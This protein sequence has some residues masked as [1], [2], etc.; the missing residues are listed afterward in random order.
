M[1]ISRENRSLVPKARGAGARAGAAAAV[2]IALSVACVVIPE[3]RA[4]TGDLLINKGQIVEA[5]ALMEAAER[6]L[7]PSAAIQVVLSNAY[8]RTAQQ[9]FDA[10]D[11]A[12]YVEHMEKAQRAALRALEINDR[13]ARAH[14]LLGIYSLYRGDLEGAIESFE[15]ARQIDP[16]VA[17]YTA[18][19]AELYVYLG[20][21]SKSR[22]RRDRARRLGAAPAALEL[23]DV[24]AAWQRGDYV[25]ARA[26]FDDTAM[27]NPQFVRTWNGASNIATFED[28]AAHCC[29]LPFCGPYMRNACSAI[30]AQVTERKLAEETALRE[31]QMKIE[32]AKRVRDLYRE[33]TDV[34]IQAAEPEPS[35]D[36]APAQPEAEAPKDPGPAPAEP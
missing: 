20:S 28:L 25:T 23:I 11:E 19:L 26:A 29:R 1:S 8:F 36:S 21:P 7:P 24:L 12:T 9:A 16:F 18:N 3:D 22:L 14:N 17:A 10:R 32:R 4:R 31:M 33:S 34:E 15:I 35:S 13:T 27:L 5:T 6:D 30:E 2:L